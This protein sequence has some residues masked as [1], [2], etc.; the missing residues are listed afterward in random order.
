MNVD[1]LG[2]E[3][4]GPIGMPMLTQRPKPKAS[5]LA[6]PLFL[7]ALIL[8]LLLAAIPVARSDAPIVIT[9]PDASR[10]VTWTFGSS[11]NL[12]LQNIE[13]AGGLAMLPWQA[14][15]VAW[16]SPDRF[17]SNLSVGVNLTAGVGGLEL[18]S[19]S[20]NHVANGDFALLS[21]WIF[22]N[23]TTG[24]V[25]AA[26]EA[27]SQDAMFR[28]NAGMDWDAFD[29]LTNWTWSAPPS[30][31]CGI[32]PDSSNKVQGSGSMKMTVNITSTA[33]WVSA[34]RSGS[35][36]WSG[37]DHLA[38]WINAT[39]AGPPLLFN[40]TAMVGASPRN[41]TAIPLTRGWNEVAVDITE[42][43]NSQERGSLQ[44]L[45]VRING[46]KLATTH[47]YFDYATLGTA[48]AL[49]ES[50]SITQPIMKSIPTTAAPGS[51]YLSFDWSWVNVSGVVSASPSA[52]L[53]GSAGGGGPA[54]RLR[55]GG[56]LRQV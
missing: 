20:T 15:T 10:T 19:D 24:Q 39:N 44:S 36:N 25:T 56:G 9:N 28:Y 34:L 1:G 26:R 21:N 37:W 13:L 12:T 48:H 16:T 7:G 8:T 27:A 14:Q 11:Q 38:V 31:C 49:D 3:Q 22:S 41:T 50:A 40:I 30:T 54:R 46:Q 35:V 18:V 33:S 2:R 47:L 5:T 43:G 23:G 4:G 29:Q 45:R 42:L 32:S 53:S 51:G 55:S 52:T 6:V 17:L